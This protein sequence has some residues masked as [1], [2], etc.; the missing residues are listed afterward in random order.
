MKKRNNQKDYKRKAKILL[1]AQRRSRVFTTWT[2]KRNFERK[3]MVSP[4]TFALIAA[5]ASEDLEIFKKGQARI[6][7]QENG[8]VC[9]RG[10]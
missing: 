1:K 6:K 9:L 7:A 3:S 8:S 10:V 4:K 2:D 5:G